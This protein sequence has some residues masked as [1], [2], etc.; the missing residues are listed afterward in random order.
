MATNKR[1]LR[2]YVRFDGTGRIIPGSLVLRRSKPKVGDWKEIQTYECC[3][4]LSCTPNYSPWRIVT[5]GQA[6]DGVVL[7]DD[8][9]EG[10]C[11]SFTFVGPNDGDGSGWVYLTQYFA[12]ETCLKIDY[13][14]ASFD[15]GTTYDR[16]V[17]WTSSTQ[18]TGEPGDTD[19]QV[20]STPDDGTW[21]ITV[22]AGQWFSLGIY[23]TDSCCGRGFLSVEICQ[24][25][26][27]T[28]T[29]TTLAP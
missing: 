22:P 24:V 20:G 11:P 19:P 26:C 6:G 8:L 5:G 12:T 3:D 13:E 18:P 1:D 4:N 9:G 28:T 2:A 14:W 10:N 23:S 25:E 17:Y 21:N 16:P 7:I 27:T 29:T 15:G